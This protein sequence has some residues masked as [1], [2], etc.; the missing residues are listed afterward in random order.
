MSDCKPTIASITLCVSDRSL[1]V[2]E[3][4]DLCETTST[5]RDGA[6]CLDTHAI[7][8]EPLTLCNDDGTK[9]VFTT[10][11]TKS[12]TMKSRNFGMEMH[13]VQETG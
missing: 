13:D 3:V 8:E 12:R 1:R 5:Q 7:H 6:Y 9:A 10:K 4:R 11:L 2:S